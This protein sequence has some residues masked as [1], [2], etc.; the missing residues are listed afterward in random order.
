TRLLIPLAAQVVSIRPIERGN[1]SVEL[2][3]SHARHLLPATSPDFEQFGAQLQ[4]A[5]RAGTPILVTENDNH[6]IIDVRP[7]GGLPPGSPPLAFPKPIPPPPPAWPWKWFKWLL[8]IWLW[9]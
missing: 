1:L 4:E 7:Y 3:P 9:P 8:P 5:M 6:E 2:M